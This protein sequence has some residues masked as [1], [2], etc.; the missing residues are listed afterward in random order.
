MIDAGILGEDDRVEM[1]H[2]ILVSMSPQS[3]PHAHAV[4]TLNRWLVR[5]CSD[6]LVVRPQLPLTL[7]DSEPEP[8]LAIVHAKDL[9]RG[10]HPSTALLVIE[11]AG[12]SLRKDRTV[13]AALYAR[14]GISEYWI[15]DL[16]GRRVHVSRD[17]DANAGTYRTQAVILDSGVLSPAFQPNT[18]LR[19]SELFA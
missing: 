3:E 9:R 1:L 14:A 11:I 10:E 18:T 15:I 4:Q 6:D 16:A 19:A 7:G 13:K 17:P 8:D 2:G 5:A 12:D